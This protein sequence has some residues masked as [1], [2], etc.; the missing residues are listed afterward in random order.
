MAHVEHR[1]GKGIE[2]V[3]RQNDPNYFNGFIA[4]WNNKQ[5]NSGDDKKWSRK[6]NPRTRFTLFGSRSIDDVTHHDVCNSIDDFRY[7]RK[8]N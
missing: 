8:D 6:K 1:I 2:K 4:S 5:K 3:V 7:K